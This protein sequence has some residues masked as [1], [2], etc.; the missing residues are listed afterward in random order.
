MFRF[1]AHL[2]R[3]ARATSPD[4]PAAA[5]RGWAGRSSSRGIS[6]PSQDTNASCLGSSAA[7]DLSG[8]RP[9]STARWSLA[10]LRLGPFSLAA[11]LAEGA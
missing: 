6:N 2:A 5:G 10:M 3:H 8:S 7:A 9:G 4:L 11:G 1:P